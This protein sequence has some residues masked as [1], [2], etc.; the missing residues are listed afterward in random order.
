MNIVFAA[1]SDLLT[2]RGGDTVQILKTKEA[3]EVLTGKKIVLCLNA[4]ELS[5]LNRI[6][7]VHV[8]NLQTT[9]VTL[10]FIRSA[11]KIGAQVVLSTIYWNLWHAAFVDKIRSRWPAANLQAVPY[12]ERFWRFVFQN[13]LIKKGFLGYEYVQ[14]KK[15]IIDSSDLLLPNSD[16]ELAS[17]A[18]D[19]CV[20]VADLMLKS[21]VVPNAVD[22][23]TLSP[24]LCGVEVP[25]VAARS[26][27]AVA[28]IGRIEPIK[29]QLSVIYALK[30]RPEI[31]MLI[32]GRKSNDPKHAEYVRHVIATGLERGN[33]CFIDEIPHEEVITFLA[34]VKV[35]VLASFRESPGLATL[36]ALYAGCNVVTSSATYCPIN[37]YSFERYGSQCNP[38]SVRSILEAIDCELNAPAPQFPKEYFEKFSYHNVAICTYGAYTT[39]FNSNN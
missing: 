11:K 1:R 28:I 25:N 37:Y 21:I 30:D 6:D 18:K 19:I 36:E 3:I 31:P 33:V 12:L 8:F 16:E 2:R 9:D 7:V 14:S 5:T 39:L 22:L 35:H 23:I 34:S 24:S 29:N 38:F 13:R 26:R 27:T 15:E 17:V 4:N 32:I 20:D 10:A